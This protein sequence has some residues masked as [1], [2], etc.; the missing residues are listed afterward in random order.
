MIGERT[1]ARDRP[2]WTVEGSGSIQASPT[3]RADAV[4]RRGADR[5]V[6]RLGSHFAKQAHRS[7]DWH[8]IV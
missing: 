8:K 3:R 5:P 1:G 4:R 7:H 6:G 2:M